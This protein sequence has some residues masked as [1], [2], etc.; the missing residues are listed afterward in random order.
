MGPNHWVTAACL[1]QLAFADMHLGD[2]AESYRL[3]KQAAQAQ[4]AALAVVLSFTSERQR[5]DYER[6]CNP[7]SLAATLGSAEDLAQIILRWKGVVLDSLLEDRLVTEASKDPAESGKIGELLA[8]RQQ[9]TQLA[10]PPSGNLSPEALQIWKAKKHN[11]SNHV[12]ELQQDIARSV[13]GLGR[14]RRALATTVPQV[15]AAL[16]PGQ[17]LV[18]M[19][20]YGYY[21]GKSESE[22]RY[23]AILIPAQG[24]PQWVPVGKAAAIEQTVKQYQ[25]AVRSDAN[26]DSV[27]AILEG[28]CG[29]VW[30]PIEKDLPPGTQTVIFSPD[31]E[32]NFVSFA[33]LLRPDGHFLAEKYSIRYVASGR[34]LLRDF[35]PADSKA[36]EIFANPDFS[37]QGAVANSAPQ[38]VSASAALATRGLELKDVNGLHLDPLPGTEKEGEALQAEAKT[39]NWPVDYY[40]QAAATETQLRAARSPYILHLATH[41][42][43]LP[44]TDAAADSPLAG[45][46][47]VGGARP[48][49]NPAAEDS[50]Q[51]LDD[52]TEDVFRNP[53]YRSGLALAGAQRTFDAWARGEM[54]P[55]E[56]DGVVTAEDV[57]ELNLEGTWLVTL[58]ACDTGIGEA[59]AGE[60]VLGLRRGFVQAGAQNLLMTLWSIADEE[61]AKLMMDFYASAQKSGNVSQALADVQRNWL[62]KLRK[63]RGLTSAVRIA[64]PFILTFQGRAQ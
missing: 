36:L 17:V 15:Q 58:S 2:S 29:Q 39:W 56:D 1:T 19:I 38:V 18:E 20:R 10:A 33:T 63:E 4:Q 55:T 37:G 23:G 7:Y 51:P 25:E 13:A 35:K 50:G 64:G 3:L 41:G 12:D 42:F 8:A 24:Q 62:V 31:G 46:R 21:I 22:D 9:L 49:G 45:L 48:L 16:A 28:L 60:G 44:D 34:D 26:D 61:T 40:H 14:A 27:Q 43:F 5:L 6:T 11:I 54:P 32:L 47:G 53:M 30:D 59:R 52:N 57:G